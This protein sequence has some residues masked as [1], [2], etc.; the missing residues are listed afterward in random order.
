MFLCI[1]EKIFYTFEVIAIAVFFS[2][3]V[4][5]I[6][7]N[8]MFGANTEK[9]WQLK[10]KNKKYFV[11]SSVFSFRSIKTLGSILYECQWFLI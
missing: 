4:L 5:R 7:L 2:V 11:K 8:K 1:N 10:I 6:F 9:M 3:D